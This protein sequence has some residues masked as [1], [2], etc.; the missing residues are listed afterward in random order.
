MMRSGQRSCTHLRISREHSEARASASFST[1]LSP[2]LLFSRLRGQRE[3]EQL[4]VEANS[5]TERQIHWEA[6]VCVF[7]LS[8]VG[9]VDLAG[10]P[11]E[12]EDPGH[13][14]LDQVYEGASSS[15]S[16]SSSS[17]SS[18]TSNQ[19]IWKTLLTQTPACVAPWQLELL[20]PGW[21]VIGCNYK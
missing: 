7:T 13:L 18:S 4:S 14:S 3:R 19:S 6:R 11:I 10:A 12:E 21:N 2:I 16:P 8:A 9:S 1:P 17:S 5:N 15:L 20:L